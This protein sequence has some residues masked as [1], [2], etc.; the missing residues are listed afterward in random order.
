M[1]RHREANTEVADALARARSLL[2]AQLAPLEAGR[3]LLQL[4]DREMQS[5]PL[6]TIAHPLLLDRLT[7]ALG[8]AAAEGVA[9][10]AVM[11]G[12][13]A[14]EGRADPRRM[15]ALLPGH[16]AGGPSGEAP[17]LR[18]KVRAAS[19]V[20]HEAAA[21]R[22]SSDDAGA[23]PGH[24]IDGAGAQAGNGE[25]AGAESE[26]V[27]IA[28]DAISRHVA[29]SEQAVSPAS[30]ADLARIRLVDTVA[31][32]ND[33]VRQMR[34]RYEGAVSW[35]RP[36]PAWVP[37]PEIDAPVPIAVARPVAPVPASRPAGLAG[38]TGV[39]YAGARE[40]GGARSQAQLPVIVPAATT[41]PVAEGP[42]ARLRRLE[43]E[44]AALVGARPERADP[45]TSPM[46][47][48]VEEAE[49]EIV[50]MRGSPV[51]VDEAARAAMPVPTLSLRLKQAER[52]IEL[53][54]DSYA[55][56]HDDA[57]EATVEIIRRP[58]AT[59]DSAGDGRDG[60]GESHAPR[61]PSRMVEQA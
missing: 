42:P 46:P 12:L 14:L 40:T 37:P 39:A 51:P 38:Q 47:A 27:D 4:V 53:D 56:C 57:D 17:R 1:R 23:D 7:A 16:T 19:S 50:V 41:A 54:G 45:A 9:Y 31:R 11:R 58:E 28:S 30:R 2:E 21:P 52:Q 60:G 34:D 24:A 26:R 25:A 20:V 43:D 10:V 61:A 59:A 29:S 32:A 13:M 33:A 48:D 6:E 15:I 22:S 35:A 18:I 49:V 36:E 44:V 55:P 3:A 5:E 8:P